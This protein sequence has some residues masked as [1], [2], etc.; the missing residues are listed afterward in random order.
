MWP[1]QIQ[2][3]DSQPNPDGGESGDSPP[4][5]KNR[6]TGKLMIIGVW[7]LLLGLLTWFAHRWYEKSENPNQTVYVGELGGVEYVQ[8][9]ANRAGHYVANGR[10]NGTEVVFLLDTGATSI[11]I[12][13]GVA[14]RI[15]IEG[16]IP[17]PVRTANGTVS[18]FA[19]TLESVQLGVFECFAVEGHINPHMSGEQILLGMSFLR[20]FDLNV[21]NNLLTISIP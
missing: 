18:V 6:Q 16:G 17:V 11:S 9:K 13:S 21:Q 20:H 19:N 7:V 8:L 14:K 4:E 15:G 2:M 10:I 5:D 1:F 3:T 12:P